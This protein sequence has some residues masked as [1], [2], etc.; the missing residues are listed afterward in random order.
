ME[1]EHMTRSLILNR[2]D[3]IPLENQRVYEI[4]YGDWQDICGLEQSLNPKKN[5]WT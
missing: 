2:K 5:P 4:P 3:K 1:H